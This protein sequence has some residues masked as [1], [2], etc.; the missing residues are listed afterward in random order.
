M[1]NYNCNY[2]IVL[3]NIHICINLYVYDPLISFVL[4]LKPL[5]SWVS[6]LPG[7]HWRVQFDLAPPPQGAHA[8]VRPVLTIRLTAQLSQQAPR[9]L[10][11][12]RSQERIHA[13]GPSYL[14]LG[15]KTPREA[16]IGSF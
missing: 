7:L 14:D 9:L 1:I 15:Q 10:Q 12:P 13:V 6:L 4:F 16:F 3:L 11:R 8:A 5:L 2:H